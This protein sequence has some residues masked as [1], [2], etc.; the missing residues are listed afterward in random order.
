MTCVMAILRLMMMN[1]L[2]KS[3]PIASGMPARVGASA[4]ASSGLAAAYASST[5]RPLTT[6]DVAVFTYGAGSRPAVKRCATRRSSLGMATALMRE[7]Q[8]GHH[9]QLRVV[10][11]IPHR[12]G[13][14]R[15]HRPTAT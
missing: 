2:M 6:S 14:G 13:Q 11:E 9:V 12:G 7:Q 1:R 5:S 15:Q 3:R 8:H 10:A 4:M